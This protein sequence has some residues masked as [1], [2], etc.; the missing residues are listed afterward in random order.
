M[1]ILILEDDENRVKKFKQNFIGCELFITHLPE[2]ANKWLEEEE[3]DWI[4][5]DHDLEYWHYGSGYTGNHST[6][7]CT[8]EYLGNNPK[9]SNK[10]KVVVHSRN[11][12]GS[13]RMFKALGDRNKFEIPFP[14][15]FPRLITIL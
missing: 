6:G 8:A 15:L 7:L 5:L 3:F 2:T 12:E 1:K 13:S 4:F 9:L 11:E 10:A 14:H